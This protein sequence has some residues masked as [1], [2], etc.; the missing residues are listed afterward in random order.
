MP[1]MTVIMTVLCFLPGKSLN[2][3]AIIELPELY[4]IARCPPTD[5]QIVYS[6][7]RLADLRTMEPLKVNSIE[8]TDCMRFLKG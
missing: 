4:M 2:V 8:I 1:L 3:Q 7:E 6:E 5:K